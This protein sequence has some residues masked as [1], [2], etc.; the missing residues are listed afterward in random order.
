[1]SRRSASRTATF[2]GV[3]ILTLAGSLSAGSAARA[4]APPSEPGVTATASRFPVEVE[5]QLG[6]V[7]IPTEPTRVVAMSIVSGV[8]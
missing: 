1:M 7:T 8:G 3:A 2:V 4:S 6:T 5:H